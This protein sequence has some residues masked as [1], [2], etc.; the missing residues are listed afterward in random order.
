MFG[1]IENKDFGSILVEL[2]TVDDGVVDR[3]H[4][5]RRRYGADMVVM[6]VDNDNSNGTAYITHGGVDA[7]RT[8]RVVNREAAVVGY[9]FAHETA[10]NLGANQDRLEY[11]RRVVVGGAGGGGRLWIQMCRSWQ[12][13]PHYNGQGI[14]SLYTDVFQHCHAICRNGSGRQ[15]KRRRTAHQLLP[16][17]NCGILPMQ[18]LFHGF[19]QMDQVA[20]RYVWRKP[21]Q[22]PANPVSL[23]FVGTLPN[24]VKNSRRQQ[25]LSGQ[26][27]FSVEQTSESAWTL[28]MDY[29]PL[30]LRRRQQAGQASE[31]PLPPHVQLLRHETICD[32]K[33]NRP[34]VP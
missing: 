27:T 20:G 12:Q 18:V 29:E 22:S 26:E 11:D 8:F 28:C 32:R 24:T 1:Y 25:G 13:V 31:N 6:I 17:Q 30:G 16:H 4:G 34:I 15:G 3:V 19:H 10:H 2:S 9:T 14:G 33:I 5:W 21:I 7:T 23:I